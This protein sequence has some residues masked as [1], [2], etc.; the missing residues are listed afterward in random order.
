MTPGGRADSSPHPHPASSCRDGLRAGRTEG[1]AL[2]VEKGFEMGHEVGFYAGHAAVWRRLRALQ[3]E[4]PGEQVPGSAAA[5]A[6]GAAAAGAE[7]GARIDRGLASLEEHI[8][9]FDLADPRDERLQEKVDAVRGKF[10]A[11]AAMMGAGD[12][13]AWPGP[14]DAA[15]PAEGSGGGGDRGEGPGPAS[16]E[17]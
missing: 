15:R 17:F 16:F 3:R 8:A 1:L 11:V 13:I 4:G 5:A 2:G 12:A 10:R 6:A 9:A 7:R 14:G